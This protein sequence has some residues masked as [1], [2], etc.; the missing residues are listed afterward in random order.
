MRK[1][2][3]CLVVFLLIS[4]CSSGK[5]DPVV[6]VKQEVLELDSEVDQS[7]LLED[8]ENVGLTFE[9]V[10]SDLN[11]SV[12]GQYTVVYRISSGKKS[13]ERSYEF[14]VKDNDAPTIEIADSIEILY[15]GSFI[16]SDYASAYD[17][18]DGDVSDSL[19]FEG[20]INTYQIGTYKITVLA[21]DRFDN[22][23]SKEV[24]INVVEDKKNTYKETICGTYTDSSYTSGQTPT[25][26]LKS[27]GSFELYLNSC[28][29]VNLV[30]GTYKQYENVLYLISPNYRF[31]Y[32]D[33]S[34]LARFI[35]QVDGTLMFDSKLELCAPNYGDVFVKNVTAQQ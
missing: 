4:G 24:T 6:R 33:E 25:L 35:I 27:D 11:T 18:R 28:S 8:V 14:I 15:G 12:A 2:V 29:V 23:T 20:I 10:S 26:T 31:A 13:V 32:P 7:T 34:D 30:E 22:E 5:F 17:Q 21:N 1:L 3:A 19:H 9:V 16:L